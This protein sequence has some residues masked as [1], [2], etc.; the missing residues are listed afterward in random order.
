[1]ANDDSITY[2]TSVTEQVMTELISAEVGIAARD[3]AIMLPLIKV[4]D[5]G[6]AP[7]P[8]A[9]FTYVDGLTASALSNEYDATSNSEFTLSEATA[10]VAE[11]TV[12][13]ELG[14]LAR[15][16]TVVDIRSVIVED[17]SSAMADV[18]DSTVMALFSG[19]TGASQN[20]GSTGT[21]ITNAAILLAIANLQKNIKGIAGDSSFFVMPPQF[22]YD[23]RSEVL[24]GSGAALATPLVRTDI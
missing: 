13:V 14:D 17:M 18:F 7:T 10:S 22:F 2:S 15:Q 21:N 19:F 1:M 4:Q 3:K 11:Y 9:A 8:Q 6:A 20:V 24:A 16:S 12:A 5:I 23:L